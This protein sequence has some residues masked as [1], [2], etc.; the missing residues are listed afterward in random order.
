MVDRYKMIDENS[1][2]EK[3]KYTYE[4]NFLEEISIGWHLIFFANYVKRQSNVCIVIRNFS[5]RINIL[6]NTGFIIAE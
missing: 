4:R 1:G 5:K 6:R 3:T 2:Q